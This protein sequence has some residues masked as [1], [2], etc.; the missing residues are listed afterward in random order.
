MAD[1]KRDENRIVTIIC[2]SEVD[3]ITPVTIAVDPTTH[4]VLV[5]VA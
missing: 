2:V 3:Y 5:E 1:A 4:A